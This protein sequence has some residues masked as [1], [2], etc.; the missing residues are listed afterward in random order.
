MNLI[1]SLPRYGWMS[2]QNRQTMDGEVDQSIYDSIFVEISDLMRDEVKVTTKDLK[3]I[4]N[5]WNKKI[6]DKVEYKHS[7]LGNYADY[8]IKTN[9][10]TPFGIG[11]SLHTQEGLIQMEDRLS[12]HVYKMFYEWWK[13]RD[14]PNRWEEINNI[15]TQYTP[16][17]MKLKHHVNR[18]RA[19]QTSYYLN[20]PI[21]TQT[22]WAG[23]SPAIPSGHC[24]N[25]LLFAALSV[26][27]HKVDEERV[28]LIAEYG[29]DI[30]LRRLIAGI[31]YPSDNIISISTYQ[32]V[33]TK[34]GLIDKLG[35][36][37]RYA[38]SIKY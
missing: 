27:M 34:L 21:V 20:I 11:A 31:H 14:Q 5:I 37:N 19:F 36:F 30:G 17:I 22:T 3:Q 28:K 23:Q 10:T 32:K 24:F 26:A 25:G 13:P 2:E 29:R 18:P 4:K 1:M 12:Y 6:T 7:E 16:L 15:M 35:N 9:V 38:L 33:I 8:L